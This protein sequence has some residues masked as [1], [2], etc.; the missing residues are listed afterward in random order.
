MQPSGARNKKKRARDEV[1]SRKRGALVLWL[2][3][4]RVEED[5]TIDEA[6]ED[7]SVTSMVSQLLGLH[8]LCK[9]VLWYQSI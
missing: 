6:T 3:R 1:D 5:K 2:K 9:V 8:E 4:S 7:S